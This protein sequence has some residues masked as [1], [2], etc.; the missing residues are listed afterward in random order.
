MNWIDLFLLFALLATLFGAVGLALYRFAQTSYQTMMDSMSDAIILLNRR[1]EIVQINLKA[2]QIL[3]LSATAVSRQPLGAILPAAVKLL[4]PDMSGGNSEIVLGEGEN[5]RYYDCRPTPRH[6]RAGRFKGWLL[7]LRDVTDGRQIAESLRSQKELFES[8]V[9]VARATAEMPTLG[10]TL[11]NAL[12][13]AARLTGAADGSV[14]LLDRDKNI[15]RQLVVLSSQTTSQ[16]EQLVGQIMV[17]GLAGWVAE[18][19][20]LAHI[21]DTMQD[22]RWLPD[23]EQKYKTRSALSVPILS[24]ADLLGILT[25]T[26]PEPNCFSRD[27]AHL[28]QAAADQVSLA[29]RNA[30][31]YEELRHYAADLNTLYS[32]AQTVAHSFDINEALAETLD[33]VIQSLHFDAGTIHLAEETQADGP[34]RLTLAASKGIPAA[35][36]DKLQREGVGEALTRLALDRSETIYIADSQSEAETNE[37]LHLSI[38]GSLEMMNSLDARAVISSPLIHQGRPLGVLSLFNQAPRL[39]SADDIALQGAIGQQIATAVANAHLFRRAVDERGQLQALIE[40]SRDGIILVSPDQRILIINPTALAALRIQGHPQAWNNRLFGQL[41]SQFSRHAPA[42]AETLEGEIS[43]SLAQLQAANSGEFELY[44]RRTHWLN[45]L[46]KSG[47]EPLGR[48][49]LLRDITQERALEQLRDDLI[50]TTVH[51]L[52]NPLT[53]IFS[54]LEFL[55]HDLNVGKLRS[56]PLANAQPPTPAADSAA[57]GGEHRLLLQIARSN[58]HRML[59]LVNAILDI[60]RLESDQMELK[61]EKILLSELISDALDHQ[62]PLALEKK[63]SLAA[64]IADDLPPAW[65]DRNLIDRVLQNLIGNGIKFTPAGG[66]VRVVARQVGAS[67]RWLQLSIIDNGPGIPIQIQPRLFQRFTT[68]G[69]KERGSGLGLA[70]CRMAMKAHEE[71]IWAENKPEG[72]AVFHFTLPIANENSHE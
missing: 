14:I 60:N 32:V 52:R 16:K 7:V 10:A 57:E 41:L 40:S 33:L 67:K 34:P 19:K 72:G 55:E 22:K 54:A 23:A 1:Q 43:R 68:G 3:N 9:A 25:L 69:Q 28:M 53:G 63:I 48:L 70:F 65:A 8:L 2:E 45:L 37:D 15:G 56:V 58:A 21:N 35:F 26:H 36:L 66:E 47:D 50:H 5:E 51:D 64:E 49:L 61:R 30:Q 42:A 29:V 71:M 44:G 11:Q 18:N 17:G 59:N 20:Q 39:F 46:V 13:V 62:L 4:D 12:E 6:G 24:G 27:H 38:P 31:M